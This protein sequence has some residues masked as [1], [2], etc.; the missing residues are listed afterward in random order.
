[1]VCAHK[2]GLLLVLERFLWTIAGPHLPWSFVKKSQARCIS[3]FNVNFAACVALS[4][5]R[6]RTI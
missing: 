2:G 6:V 5:Q 4:L 3:L 1:M